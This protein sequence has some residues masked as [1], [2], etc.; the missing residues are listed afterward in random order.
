MSKEW[1]YAERF[2]EQMRNKQG[3]TNGRRKR[4]FVIGIS[5]IVVVSGVIA[6][7]FKLI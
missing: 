3:D 1:T 5:L 7:L 4:A 6:I 2:K